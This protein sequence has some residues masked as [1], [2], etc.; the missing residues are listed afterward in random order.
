LIV[1]LFMDFLLLSSFSSTV[2]LAPVFTSNG[3]TVRYY[4]PSIS[5]SSS[6]IYVTMYGLGK[7]TKRTIPGRNSSSSFDDHAYNYLARLRSIDRM[8]SEGGLQCV[9]GNHHTCWK[10]KYPMKGK[11]KKYT[12][13]IIIIIIIKVEKIEK[14]NAI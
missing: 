3:A 5:S 6:S 2:L 4:P 12:T 9:C 7:R 13:I 8:T 1:L 10:T 11:R 14:I